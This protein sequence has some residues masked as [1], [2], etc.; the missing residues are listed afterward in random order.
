MGA[1]ETRDGRAVLG[2]DLG[3][4]GLDRCEIVGTGRRESRFDD[5]DTEASELPGDPAVCAAMP[6]GGVDQVGNV[7]PMGGGPACDMGSYESGALPVELVTFTV[8]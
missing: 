5:I 2:P 1:G 8:D 3:G 7:R 4:D 6:V